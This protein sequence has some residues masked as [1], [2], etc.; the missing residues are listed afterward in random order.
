MHSGESVGIL[1]WRKQG[2]DNTRTLYIRSYPVMLGFHRG[3]CHRGG[4][5]TK[6]KPL[7]SM[8]SQETVQNNKSNQ[9]NE[10]SASSAAESIWC[11]ALSNND[12]IMTLN[13]KKQ[14]S[15]SHSLHSVHRIASLT[16]RQHLTT[17]P[18]LCSAIPPCTARAP[19]NGVQRAPMKDIQLTL[20]PHPGTHNHTHD[21]DSKARSHIVHRCTQQCTKGYCGGHTTDAHWNFSVEE[22]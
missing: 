21:A 11:T 14:C 19:N 9:N 5:R 4:T 1:Y 7:L 22:Q 18:Q 3:Y 15:V 12:Q 8:A 10:C 6:A 17:T 20:R 16:S 2:C 13:L